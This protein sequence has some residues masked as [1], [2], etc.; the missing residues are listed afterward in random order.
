VRIDYLQSPNDVVRQDVFTWSQESGQEG[1]LK[2]KSIQLGNNIFH[3]KS[4][5]YDKKGNIIRETIYGNLSGERP[6]AFNNL[7]NTDQYSI[8]Y[9]YSED[10]FNLLLSKTTPQGYSVYY[11]Y[12][13]ETNLLTKELHSYSG[14][15]Q[16]RNFYFY[17]DNGQKNKIIED[18]G[19]S[20]DDSDMTDVTYRR[21]KIIDPDM[22]I[23]ASFGKPKQIREEIFNKDNGQI[24][25][26]KK[27]EFFYDIKGNVVGQKVYNSQNMFCYEISK[28]YDDRQR[29]IQESNPL[30]HVRRYVYDDNNNKIE[31]ELLGS[32]MVT[33]Y[34]YDKGNGLVTKAEQHQNGEKFVTNYKYDNLSQLISE[35]DPYGHET[36]YA[37]DRLGRQT[38]IKK[39][40]MQVDNS[41]INPSIAKKYNVLDQITSET[42]ENGQT[43]DFSYN[44]YGSSTKITYSDNSSER[45][46]YYPNGWLKQKCSQDGS[47]TSYS[48]D[49]KGRILK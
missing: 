38:Q 3:L 37:Y 43:T 41:L 25:P 32:G 28:S 26:L 9:T 36:S 10:E 11:S 24:I 14:K 22:S 17:D 2:E 6:E 8:E 46:V 13:P 7:Q 27:T 5:D 29:L 4:Y 35:I 48:Y 18:D 44:A 12:L 20:Q 30:G 15:I 33:R 49:P 1:W 16:E 31:E 45:F 23:G 47:S 40:I 21:V 39:P 42:N 19:S 34:E